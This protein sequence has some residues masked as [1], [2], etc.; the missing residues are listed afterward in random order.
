MTDSPASMHVADLESD[1]ILVP[2]GMTPATAILTPAS[3]RLHSIGM[4]PA[5]PEAARLY[6]IGESAC[7]ASVKFHPTGNAVDDAQTLREVSSMIATAHPAFIGLTNAPPCTTAIRP[8]SPEALALAGMIRRAVINGQAYVHIAEYPADAGVEIYMCLYNSY[9]KQ[10]KEVLATALDESLQ[11]LRLSHEGYQYTARFNNCRLRLQRIK[12]DYHSNE[13]FT[14]LYLNGLDKSEYDVFKVQW[15]VQ[16]LSLDEIQSAFRRLQTVLVSDTV[17][18]N[19]ALS[20]PL[21]P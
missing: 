2:P 12:P 5:T 8:H 17:T 14:R 9:Y 16:G 13:Y 11:M 18:Q 21:S 1:E 7:Y 20:T 6:S 3:G 19:S 15:R 4:T 10:M